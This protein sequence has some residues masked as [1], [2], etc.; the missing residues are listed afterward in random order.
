MIM[1]PK[2]KGHQKDRFLFLGSGLLLMIIVLAGFAKAQRWGTRFVDIYMNARDV[3]G[4]NK[5]EEIRIAGIV[6]G[7][8]GTMKLNDQGVVKVKLKIEAN[9]IHLIGP[10]SSARLG[11]EGWIGAPFLVITTDPRPR[12]QA[13]DIEGS[14][15]SYEE[16]LNVNTLLKELANSQQ[17]LNSTLRNTSAL[18]AKDGSINTAIN[19]TR[20]LAESLQKE[21]IATAPVA[22]ESISSVAKDIHSVSESTEALE[23]D[24]RSFIEETQPLVIKTLKDADQLTRSSQEVIDLLRNLFGYWLEPVKGKEDAQTKQD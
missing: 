4:L 12:E 2:Q 13:L 15:I 9:K 21:V 5:G 22:R 16:T 19:A 1:S 17:Q 24:T 20:Q 14:T 8:V 11:K 6:A 10:S 23:Q 3:N 7:Q 18:T